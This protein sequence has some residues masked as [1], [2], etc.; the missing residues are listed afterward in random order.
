MLRIEGVSKRFRK[1]DVLK[2]FNLSCD[3]GEIVVL[4]GPNG[5]GKSTTLRMIAGIVK[6]DSGRIEILGGDPWVTE[7]RES[8]SYLPQRIEFPK[9]YRAKDVLS[10]AAEIRGIGRGRIQE[11]IER[12]SMEKW[13]DKYVKELSGGMVQRLALAV[14]FMPNV[15][16]YLLDEPSNNLDFEGLQAFRRGIG[17][18]VR[19]GATVVLSTHSLVEAEM[20][21]TRVVMLWKGKIVKEEPAQEF[22]NRINQKRKLWVRLANPDDRYLDLLEKEAEGVERSLDVFKVSVAPEKRFSVLTKLAE[23]GAVVKEFG[24]EEPDLE[25]IYSVFL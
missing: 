3:R 25:E 8:L 1:E 19:K 2:A 11:M 12:F 17:E 24:L 6:G 10:L 22:F 5:S 9:Y 7:T 15:P 20:L 13:L 16:L 4:L 18:I 23:N 14:T 21:A